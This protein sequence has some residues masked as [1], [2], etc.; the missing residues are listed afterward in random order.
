M[1]LCRCNGSTNPF[2]F[3]P[4]LYYRAT[5]TINYM[6]RRSRTGTRARWRNSFPYRRISCSL[7]EHYAAWPMQFVLILRLPTVGNCPV[8]SQLT[9]RVREGLFK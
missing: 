8:L 5:N 6:S 9:N 7:C 4:Q 1:I 3:T 2:F